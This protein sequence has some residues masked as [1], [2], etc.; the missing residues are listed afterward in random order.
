MAVQ[1]WRTR[2]RRASWRGVPFF[3]DE[4]RGAVGRRIEHH[5][6]PQRDQPWAE[7]LGRARRTWE[8]SGY[9]LGSTYMTTRDRMISACQQKG[10]GK[11]VHP[12]LGELTVVCNGMRYV[13]RDDDGG[14]CRFEFSFAE[15][16]TPGAPVG[17][18]A[19]GA[20][21]SVAGSALASASKFAFSGL[22]FEVAG[23]PDF[24]AVTAAAQL[25]E[26]ARMLDALRGPTLQVP[27][28][29][30]LA[31]QE[32]ILALLALD[33]GTASPASIADAV[34]GAIAA[35]AEGV[36]PATALDGLDLL[37]QVMF[38]GPATTPT[39]ARTQQGE[40]A[41]CLTALTQQA[42]AAALP[43]PLATYPLAVYDD[44]V[45]VRTRVVTI[46]DRVLALAADPVFLALAELRD[47]AITELAVRGATLVPLVRYSTAQAR[48]SLTLAQAFY[49]DPARADELVARTG[50]VHP[51]FLPTSGLVAGA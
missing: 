2:L 14:I 48:P 21:L 10:S 12:Y 45:A 18:R 46:C 47:Q 32:R 28:A 19:A 26:L 20:M 42:A 39:P 17:I 29:L 11:L 44:L 30:S 37:S 50:A 1:V 7:D 38:A 22:S 9:A 51:A 23:W 25:A 40:N 33:P 5:E 27:T 4:A 41:R 6:Y 16:G 8:L 31:A 36:S 13:E 24:V 3:I 43:A 35:F 49:Q 34:T 15:P